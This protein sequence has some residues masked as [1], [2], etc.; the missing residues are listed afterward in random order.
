MQRPRAEVRRGPARCGE[1]LQVEI[2]ATVGGTGW[3]LGQSDSS[4]TAPPSSWPLL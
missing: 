4:L 1:W 3:E 2:L